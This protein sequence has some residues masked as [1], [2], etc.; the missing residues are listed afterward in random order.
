[1]ILTLSLS[2]SFPRLSQ[3][4]QVCR[5]AAMHGSLLMKGFLQIHPKARSSTTFQVKIQSIAHTLN[6]CV[7]HR[8]NGEIKTR[9]A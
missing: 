5:E 8:A 6:G 7:A 9:T 4:E 2:P 3:E 1:M